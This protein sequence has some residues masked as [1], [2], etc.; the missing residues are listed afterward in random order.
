MMMVM[1]M[2]RHRVDEKSVVRSVFVILIPIVEGFGLEVR[3]FLLKRWVL[4][5]IRFVSCICGS[6]VRQTRHVYC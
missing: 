4:F 2:K 3:W 6:K 1:K 5:C